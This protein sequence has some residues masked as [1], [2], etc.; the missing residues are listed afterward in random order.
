MNKPIS[1][2][3]SMLS[4]S[5]SNKTEMQVFQTL[6]REHQLSEKNKYVGKITKLE[7]KWL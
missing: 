6:K 2:E 1:K 3:A 5:F 7:M 4:I